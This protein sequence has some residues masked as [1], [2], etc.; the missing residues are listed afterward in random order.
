MAASSSTGEELVRRV[1]RGAQRHA[2]IGIPGQSAPPI[3]LPPLLGEMRTV[4]AGLSRHVG[5]GRAGEVRVAHERARSLPGSSRPSG[6]F[7]A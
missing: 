4:Y 1:H 7:V 3:R 6:S 5:R 2:V